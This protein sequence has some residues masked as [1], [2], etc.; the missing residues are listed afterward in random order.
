MHPYHL[1]SYQHV[2][3]SGEPAYLWFRQTM[4]SLF[5]ISKSIKLVNITKIGVIKTLITNF[6]HSLEQLTILQKAYVNWPR[7]SSAISNEALY[8]LENCRKL[9]FLI[10]VA[11]TVPT[12][13]TLFIRLARGC[14][15]YDHEKAQGKRSLEAPQGFYLD[16][17]RLCPPNRRFDAEY[18]AESCH[19]PLYE[20]ILYTKD[21]LM[22]RE[23]NH[24]GKYMR[25]LIPRASTDLLCEV[26]ATR[27]EE[28]LRL[29]GI[30]G[31]L[32]SMWY[33]QQLDF[34]QGPFLPLLR[35]DIKAVLDHMRA[36]K[37]VDIYSNL[38]MAACAVQDCAGMSKR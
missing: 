8:E 27:S 19:A 26:P 35:V 29:S 23:S 24:P 31:H 10:R 13:G 20:V 11:P 25:S 14:A 36:A 3:I 9:Y 16:I 28:L 6:A 21:E 2:N 37:A 32:W 12:D 33:D 5:Q 34:A 1:E 17:D 15:F 18:W 22:W 4:V 38:T 30:H 7:S